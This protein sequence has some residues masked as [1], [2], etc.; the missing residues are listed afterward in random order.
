MAG[1]EVKR[2]SIE[3]QA[4]ARALLL[5]HGWQPDQQVPYR[6][7]APVLMAQVG[8]AID[9]AKRNMVKAGR[10][11][12]GEQAAQWGGA[13]PGAGRPPRAKHAAEYYGISAAYTHHINRRL[14]NGTVKYD[15]MLRWEVF[16]GPVGDRDAAQQQAEEA[17]GPIPYGRSDELERRTYHKNLKVVPKSKLRGYGIRLGQEAVDRD[18]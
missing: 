13:R 3:I 11:L 6:E 18:A 14:A 16:S 10:V 9:T 7:L 2:R 4:A 1:A 17:I 5:A 8:C 12:R 15:E